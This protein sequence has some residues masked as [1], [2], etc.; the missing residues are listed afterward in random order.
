MKE[1]CEKLTV[2]V[3]ANNSS[4]TLAPLDLIDIALTTSGAIFVANQVIS[5]FVSGQ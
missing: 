3:A 4:V 1:N 2:Y 5:G